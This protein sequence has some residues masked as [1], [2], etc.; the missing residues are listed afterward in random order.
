MSNLN[1]FHLIIKIFLNVI[2][3]TQLIFAY[4]IAQEFRSISHMKLN[5]IYI[6]LQIH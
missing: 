3:D 4:K 1:T 2:S 5:F 6:N